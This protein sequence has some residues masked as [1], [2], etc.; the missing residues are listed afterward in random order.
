MLQPGRDVSCSGGASLKSLRQAGKTFAQV[1]SRSVAMSPVSGA[2]TSVFFAKASAK[3]SPAIFWHL[4]FRGRAAPR[5]GSQRWSCRLPLIPPT[6]A[7][8]RRSNPA[9]CRSLPKTGVFHISAGDY[10]LFGSENLE[11]LNLETGPSK[12]RH[13]CAFLRASRT[14]SLNDA[15]PGWRRSADCTR[16]HAN[17]QLTGNFPV[18][19]LQ[20][21]IS[22]R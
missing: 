12:A 21:Q 3:N 4:D 9:S 16:L 13:W 7:T 18:L 10:R 17:S 14:L 11:D 19:G 20:A 8:Q 2:R 1:V 5:D 15:L 6:R 22:Y